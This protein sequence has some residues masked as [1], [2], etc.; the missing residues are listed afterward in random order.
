[1]PST[2]SPR[3]RI[4]LIGDGEQVGNW[5]QTTNSN[6]GTVVDQA[7]AGYG[8]IT[9]IAA[10]QALTVSNGAADEARNAMLALNT[11]TGADFAV[12]IPPV[13]KLYVVANVSAYT[14]TVYNSTVAGNTTAA[15]TGVAVPAGKRVVIMTD[16]TDCQ[17]VGVISTSANTANTVVERDGSGNFAAGTITANLTGDVTGNVTGNVA[18]NV[19]GSAAS[20]TGVN[21]VANGGTGADNAVEAKDNLATG[22]LEPNSQGASYELAATDVGDMVAISDGSITVPPGVFSAGQVV[23]VYNQNDTT[24][25]SIIRG[26]GV[27]MYWLGGANADRTLAV[28]G[29]ASILCV[30]SN[31]FVITGQGIT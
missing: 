27:S 30:A 23:V 6:L 17:S 11:T 21:P 1:M 2:F 5:G 18:G 4:E 14:A 15:G 9:T 28:R 12:Y 24:T 13:S 25:R 29:V 26:S 20:I 3:L 22:K 10:Q 8:A 31:E 19:S 7:V 16:G